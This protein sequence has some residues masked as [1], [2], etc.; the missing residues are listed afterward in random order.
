MF[1]RLADTWQEGLKF[2]DELGGP[3]HFNHFPAQWAW[4][5]NTPFQYAKAV[6]SHF[7]GT[8][9]PLII[10]WP[11]RIK[12]KGGLRTQFHDVIDIAPTILKAAGVT[13]PDVLN[14]VTQSPIQGVDMTY[15]FD[16]AK[17]KDQR[18]M[19]VFELAGNRAIYE[20]GWIASS[21][22][23]VPWD[24]ATQTLPDLDKAKWEL[25]N[26][27]EDFSQADDLAAKHPEKL[28]ALKDL[29]NRCRPAR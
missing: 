26:L 9:N 29:A 14:G 3:K 6:A 25:Y 11:A 27:A 4:A 20:N 2:I 18:K 5:M 21:V 17:A 7:G 22:V 24:I 15:S 28:S 1:N 19:M 12:D 8:R 13:A 10:S 16:D 23:L